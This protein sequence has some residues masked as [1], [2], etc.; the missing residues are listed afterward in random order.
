MCVEP[1]DLIVEPLRIAQF[2]RA[3][4]RL[5]ARGFALAEHKKV[6]HWSIVVVHEMRPGDV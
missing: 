2:E 6:A 3:A 1:L 4:Q 5:E